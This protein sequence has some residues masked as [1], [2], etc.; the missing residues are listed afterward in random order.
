MKTRNQKVVRYIK[1]GGDDI[2]TASEEERS[3]VVTPSE[4]KRLRLDKGTETG[5][6]TALQDGI[7]YSLTLVGR[8][9]II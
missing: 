4:N 1:Y 3:R 6:I 8:P 9:H 7:F 5:D 2:S